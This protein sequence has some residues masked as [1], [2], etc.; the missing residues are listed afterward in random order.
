MR[1]SYAVWENNIVF[2][3]EK[4]LD[5]NQNP[6]WRRH[7]GWLGVGFSHFTLLNFVGRFIYVMH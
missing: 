1:D 7:G 4:I 5:F 6:R 3:N 2:V